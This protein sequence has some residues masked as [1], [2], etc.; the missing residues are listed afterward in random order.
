MHS[1]TESTIRAAEAAIELCHASLWRP[2]AH[3]S[4]PGALA[5]LV[6]RQNAANPANGLG[7]SA[8]GN[9]QNWASRPGD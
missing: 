2:G 4:F 1:G 9:L 3:F 7:G 5:P 6:T 8:R